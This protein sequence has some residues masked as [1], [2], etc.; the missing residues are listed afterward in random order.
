MMSG[1]RKIQEWTPPKSLGEMAA[2][3][4]NDGKGIRCP[5]C[6]CAHWRVLT[7]WEGEGFINRTRVCQNQNCGYKMTTREKPLGK[8]A[9]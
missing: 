1:E 5:R 8:P 7:T 3:S 6:N 2:E 4:M 9:A